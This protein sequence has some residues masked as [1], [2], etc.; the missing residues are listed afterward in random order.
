MLSSALL[1]DCSSGCYWYC[2]SSIRSCPL[3]REFIFNSH[4]Y[5][6][7]FSSDNLGLRLIYI[8][9]LHPI[10]LTSVIY[11]HQHVLRHP[12]AR[13]SFLA[14]AQPTYFLFFIS[15]SIILPSPTLSS[16]TDFFYFV[17]SFCTL[18][19]SQYPHLKCLQSFCSFL[20]RVQVSVPC[21][22]TFHRDNFSNLF[23]SFFKGRRKS[24]F[25]VK[26]FFCHCYPLL[27]FLTAVHL[28]TDI[29]PQVYE[30]V[31][32]FDGFIFN[33]HVYLLWFPSW[34]SSYLYL[35]SSHNPHI[36]HVPPSACSSAS[37][38]LLLAK[39]HHRQILCTWYFFL[40]W[41]IFEI[42]M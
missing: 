12:L 40:L 4:V 38:H 29:T 15:F 16:T 7:W 24:F 11:L 39:L 36:C 23:H 5:L 14:S 22:T 3:V 33:S 6:L 13:S 18:H 8:F 2:T 20:R 34:P 27:Y 1:L 31:H 10:I 25:S 30:A 37:F 17:C 41:F 32:L 21:N 35:S 9:Y 26:S 42:Y 28:V 19:F